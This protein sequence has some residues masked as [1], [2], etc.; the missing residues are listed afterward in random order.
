MSLEEQKKLLI[1]FLQRAEEVQK[2]EPKI[3]YYCRLY[4]VEQ[5][6]QIPK[7]ERL[8]EING[9]LGALLAKCEK[10]RAS[11]A[12]SK[13]DALYCEDFALKVFNRADR[14]DRAGRADKNT[15]ITFYAASYFIEILNQF[16]ELQPDILARQ[17]YAAWRAA[18][19]NKAIKEGRTPAP[20]APKPMVSEEDQEYMDSLG[21][22][23][24]TD[25]AGAASGLSSAAS[26]PSGAPPPAPLA[27]AGSLS[28]GL[29]SPPKRAL[30]RQAS[31]REGGGGGGS[32]AYV[33]PP[34]LTFHPFQ[35]VLYFEEGAPAPQRGT[36]A[37]VEP[38]ADGSGGSPTY[39]VALKG[40]P[41]HPEETWMYRIAQAEGHCLAP[42]L[43]PEDRVRYAAPSGEVCEATVAQIDTS[44]WPPSYLIRCDNGSYVDTIAD[45]LEPVQQN[46]PSEVELQR[47]QQEQQA[48]QARRQPPAAAAALPPA[49]DGTGGAYPPPPGS[50]ASGAGS[51]AAAP[52][53]TS[54]GGPPPGAPGAGASPQQP[55]SPSKAGYPTLGAAGPA[56]GS[57]GSR[58]PLHPAPPPAGAAAGSG[59]SHAAGPRVMV[60]PAAAPTGSAARGPTP[61]AA[62]SPGAPTT[63]V[64]NLTK[65]VAGF[66]PSLAA[67]TEA[68]KLSKTASSALSFED[69]ATAVKHLTEALALLTQPGAPAPG[70]GAHPARR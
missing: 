11:L 61:G 38:P 65:P 2:A 59:S 45:R 3:A 24:S 52:P 67:I 36:I 10:D 1:P 51:A 5:A 66:Q 48:Q 43:S 18:D 15:A 13:D 37:K 55:S 57:A 34:P 17:R 56:G 58:A 35:K 23:P 12:L 16:G 6:L 50:V 8:P 70:A 29:P 64:T 46:Q 60:G 49:V 26:Q 62:G 44:H 21:G 54:S 30:S 19:I 4:A 25:M 22:A 69:V 53:P 47:L 7:P 28:D 27:S 14:V 9:L 41:K 42:E 63:P 39:F 68:Q 31:A 40:T 20:P 33:A 32:V